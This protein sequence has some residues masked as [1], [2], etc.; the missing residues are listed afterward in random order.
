[1]SQDQELHD[2]DQARAGRRIKGKHVKKP[3]A[4]LALG[5]LVRGA[6]LDGVLR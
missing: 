2:H 3:R 1:M 4:A 5:S 6:R